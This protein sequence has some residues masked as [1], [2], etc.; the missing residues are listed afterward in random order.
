MGSHCMGSHSVGGE[1]R[2]HHVAAPLR[3]F[4]GARFLLSGPQ[5]KRV[6]TSF[7]KKLKAGR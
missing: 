6:L 4:V 7:I 3:P 5:V 2:W 1:E